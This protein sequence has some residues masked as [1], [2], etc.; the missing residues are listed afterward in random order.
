MTTVNFP[1][2]WRVHTPNLL[3]EI[4]SYSKQPVLRTPIAILGSLLASV[5]ERA[6]VLNDPELNRLMLRLT[7]YS[8]ADPESEDYDPHCLDLE[9]T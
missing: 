4:A 7:I 2:Q 6:T 3:K 9:T 1:N 8:A 5:G